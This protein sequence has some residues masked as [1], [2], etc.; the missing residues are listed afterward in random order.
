MPTTQ[1]TIGSLILLIGGLITLIAFFFLPYITKIDLS[2][3]SQAPTNTPFVTALVSQSAP[4]VLAAFSL[5]A[6]GFSAEGLSTQ[7]VSRIPLIRA[8]RWLWMLGGLFALFSLFSDLVMSISSH[9]AFHFVLQDSQTYSNGSGASGNSMSNDI[10]YY[11][12]SGFWLCLIGTVL[13]FVGYGMLT[14]TETQLQENSKVSFASSSLSI[15][16]LI[17]AVIGTLLALAAFLW[18]PYITTAQVVGSTMQL[19]T[20]TALSL[21]QNGQSLYWLEGLSAVLLLGGIGWY[22]YR[23]KAT[24]LSVVPRIAKL[25]VFVSMLVLFFLL[26]SYSTHSPGIVVNTTMLRPTSTSTSLTLSCASDTMSIEGLHS[27]STP[28]TV[29]SVSLVA[30][31]TEAA[32][33]I[34]YGPGF[35]C[36][37]LGMVFVIVGVTIQEATSGRNWV[38]VSSV[39]A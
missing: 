15:L 38:A 25:L 26:R 13:I 30:A 29:T 39:K 19:T 5:L 9:V 34:D 8:M 35:W 6:L 1:R 4:S 7:G 27:S 12:G 11:T 33:S 32:P 18:L 10:A 22:I 31:C 36:A 14:R 24:Q 23:L 28:T 21:A 16:G 2:S 20:A 17:L 37:I 3:I